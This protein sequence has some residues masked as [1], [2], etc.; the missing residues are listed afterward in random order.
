MKMEGGGKW[1]HLIRPIKG[2][3]NEQ[4]VAEIFTQIRPVWIGEFETRTKTY[5]N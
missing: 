3:K 1:Y 5:Q 2:P 4:F